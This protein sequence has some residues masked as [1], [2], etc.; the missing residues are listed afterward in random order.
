MPKPR[1]NADR[2]IVT[3]RCFVELRGRKISPGRRAA[4][5]DERPWLPPSA[6]TTR[7]DDGNIIIITRGRR[8]RRVP[9][10]CR[11]RRRRIPRRGGGGGYHHVPDH[12]PRGRT[13]SRSR[14]KKNF[15]PRQV[16]AVSRQTAAASSPS[17]N[18][19]V[20]RIIL[21]YTTRHAPWMGNI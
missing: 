7:R 20:T 3:A 14:V 8:R 1:V 12:R 19:R 11:S 10:F 21:S 18:L 13:R 9:G 6:A 2:Y 5:V 4:R 17:C 15:A 16:A